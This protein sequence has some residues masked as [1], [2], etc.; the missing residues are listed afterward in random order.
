M[1]SLGHRAQISRFLVS[2][3]LLIAFSSVADP[4]DAAPGGLDPTFDFDGRVTTQLSGNNDVA[5]ATAIQTDGKILAAGGGDGFFGVVR[6]LPDGKLDP[7]FSGDGRLITAFGSVQDYARGVG[8]Q[9]DGKIV[10]AGETNNGTD[11]DFAVARYMPD[12]TLDSTFSGDGKQTTGIGPF[13]DR[14][15]AMAL[16]SDGKI[17]VAGG[18]YNPSAEGFNEFALVRY[19]SNG[20]LD[21]DFSG[22]GIVTTRITTAIGDESYSRAVAVQPNGMIVAAGYCLIGDSIQLCLA[23]FEV[24]GDLDGTFSDDGKLAIPIADIPSSIAL[25]ADGKIVVAG[26]QLVGAAEDFVIVRLEDD[27]TLDDTFGGDGIVTTPVGT[28]EDIANG[29]AI[30]SDG[31]IIVAGTRVSDT[32]SDFAVV[33]Y[34]SDGDLDPSFSSDGIQTIEIG[35]D[36]D[37]GLALTLD[38]DGKIVVAGYTSKGGIDWD[39]AVTRFFSEPT[40]TPFTSPGVVRK[41]VWHLSNGFQ[42]VVDTTFA[43]AGSKDRPLVGDWDGDGRDEPAAVRTNVWHL[44][45]GVPPS[46]V[47]SF[48]FA[49]AADTPIAGDWDRDGDD[50]PGV[51]R[52]NVWFLSDNAP[53]TSVTSFAFGKATDRP[54]AGDWDGDGDDEPGVVR[55]N[56]WFLSDNAPPTSVTSFAFGKASDTP[57]AGDWNGDGT[58]SPGVVR[59][60]TW[61]LNTVL[62]TPTLL[63]FVLGAPTDTF[64]AGSWEG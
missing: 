57:I 21:P 38:H 10:V 41:N 28:R 11:I 39:F 30:Q 44:A 27:G 23:R 54:I 47:T 2:I 48:P 3:S 26:S 60:S 12:G 64:V 58:D 63:I 29:V 49:G 14:P 62:G 46:S 34:E 35:S 56:V 45:D 37:E 61:Y 1:R 8:V 33:R 51:V 7:T 53:P 20:T 9:L 32:D 42:G 43:F 18:S 55:G 24:D 13:G 22:D 16:Q 15:E 6:Y 25:Q 36:N 59:G 52:G 17:I 50:E 31:K 40:L 19:A 4:S 5:Y